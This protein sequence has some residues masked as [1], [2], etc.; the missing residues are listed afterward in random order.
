MRKITPAKLRSRLPVVKR[1]NYIREKTRV[2]NLERQ[3]Q[4]T[5]QELTATRQTLV[6]TQNT[7]AEFQTN[8]KS[9]REYAKWLAMNFPTATTLANQRAASTEFAYRPMISVIMPVFNTKPEYLTACIDS[10]IAQSYVNWELCIVDDASDSVE[11]MEV[12]NKY[13]ATSDPRI[14]I[15]HSKK[16]G[17]ISAASNIA[18]KKATGEFIA[19]LDHDDLLW[20][21]ALFEVVQLLQDHTDA[22]FVYSDE[23]K[24]EAD[25]YLHFSPY[26]KPDWSPRLLECINYV[27]HF[28][29]IRTELV[30]QVGGFDTTMV[31]TQDWDLFLR[32]TEKTNKVYHVPTVLYSWRAHE[33]STASSVGT[34][35]YVFVN[36]ERALKAHFERV[37]PEYEITVSKGNYNFWYPKYKVI[38]KPSVSVVIPTKDKVEYLKRCIESI[39]DKTDYRKY[40][41]IIVD[42]GSIE[43]ET[44]RY[45]AHLEDEYGKKKV[46]IKRYTKQPF[47]Y[48]NA[49]NFGAKH[50]KGEYLVMLNNDTEVLSESWI[51]DMLGYAQQPDVAAVGAKLLYTSGQIQHA[52]MALGIGSW[53]PVAAHPGSQ[54]ENASS[55]PAQIT[56]THTVRDVSGVTAAC[57][58]VSA[59]KFWQVGGFDPV[60]RVTFNDVD[61][62][63]K[64]REAG[65]TNI[66]LPFVELVHS[67]SISVGRVLQDR[68]MTELNRS[69]ELMRQRWK[70]AIDSDPFYNKN[71]FIL[72][73]QFELSVYPELKPPAL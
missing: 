71:F 65:Y 34:K 67:E 5:N 39:L 30:R 31:G 40:E 56:Y 22:D 42:T 41:I 18:I 14:H 27:T 8:T 28:S 11:T 35:S 17:H 26:F 50:A 19:L 64:F 20:P 12:L 33:G 54:M 13:E 10:V 32:V 53:V 37:K 69:A 43:H 25:G 21:N 51:K 1:S 15:T 63:L 4:Q 6:D 7:L 29:V 52:G 57:L 3:I 62:N 16:N 46:R 60:Y 55:N 36:Q 58:M 61:L 49:C 47:N 44:H 9:N 23:D 24:I 59:S 68:D 72:S 45:Y 66:Y 38:G 48:S 70:D 2:D 73:S